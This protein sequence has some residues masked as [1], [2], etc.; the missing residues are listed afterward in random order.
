M[1]HIVPDWLGPFWLGFVSTN[2]DS[3]N[4]TTVKGHHHIQR[5]GS[6]VLTPKHGILR[7]VPSEPEVL[8]FFV[9][10]TCQDIARCVDKC[11]N[12]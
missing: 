11:D 6:T 1:H 3:P 2:G 5:K 9:G 12:I 7:S 10:A 4:L 8:N